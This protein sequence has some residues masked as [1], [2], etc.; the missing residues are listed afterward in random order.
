MA[1]YFYEKVPGTDVLG[2]NCGNTNNFPTIP[3]KIHRI[4]TLVPVWKS[5]PKYVQKEPV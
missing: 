5:H 3:P 4:N 2:V 1:T